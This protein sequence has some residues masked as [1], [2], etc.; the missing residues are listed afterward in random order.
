MPPTPS[1]PR[2]LVNISERLSILGAI[3]DG[4][5]GGPGPDDPQERDRFGINVRGN[6]LP[7]LLG[8][9][10]YAWNNKKGDPNS[11]GQIKLGGWRHLGAFS[12]QRLA[13]SGVSLAASTSSGEPLLLSGDIG[14]WAVFEQKLYR[15]PH[16]DDR[17]IS[18]F[19]ACQ[20]QP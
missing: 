1:S 15:V 12:D 14:G 5:Q 3:F 16:S 2:L 17:G 7:L 8:Q 11:A 4:N 9:I 19:A 6:D 20:A 18:V 10:Q 13:S